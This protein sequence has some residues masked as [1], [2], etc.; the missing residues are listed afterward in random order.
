MLTALIMIWIIKLKIY[1]Y[2]CVYVT[3]SISSINHMDKTIEYELD[4]VVQY[5]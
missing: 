1:I 3:K 4:N 5:T 2:N